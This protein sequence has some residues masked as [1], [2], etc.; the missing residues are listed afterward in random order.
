MNARYPIPLV[1]LNGVFDLRSSYVAVDV[2]V[3]LKTTVK[4]II[5][6]T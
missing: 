3:K 2:G 5:L 1:V 6:V 4:I